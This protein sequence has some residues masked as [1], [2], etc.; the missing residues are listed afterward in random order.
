VPHQDQLARS[1]PDL[2]DVFIIILLAGA[3]DVFIFSMATQFINNPV[4]QNLPTFI[5]DAYK[6]V[7][8]SAVAG[9]AGIGAAI[10][11][12]FSRPSGSQTPNYLVYVLATAAGIFVLIVGLAYISLQL[13]PRTPGSSSRSLEECSRSVQ[14]QQYDIALERCGQAAAQM[15][16][17]YRAAHFLGSAQYHSAQ[18]AQAINTFLRALDLPGADRPVVLYNI[19]FAQADN[20]DARGA[21]ESLKAALT[22]ASGRPTIE[23]RIWMAMGS[24]Q[25]DLW[26]ETPTDVELFD[27]AE[28]AYRAFLEIGKI[29]HWARGGL[30]C[31]YAVRATTSDGAETK[32][33]YEKHAVTQFEAALVELRALMPQD[34]K[35]AEVKAFLAEFGPDS[36]SKCVVPLK[37][38]WSA[39]KQAAYQEQLT[40]LQR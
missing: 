27:K 9:T 35:T 21:I 33:G 13:T 23:A 8:T 28:K 34:L 24:I 25:Q 38:A 36:P 18:Y 31:L 2:I 22:S 3:V 10:V 15:P 5:T 39:Q 40:G 12:A 20:R 17:D 26:I 6:A 37:T 4:F 11:K 1:N 32:V 14:A 29:T 16:H 7:W 30:A 19:A